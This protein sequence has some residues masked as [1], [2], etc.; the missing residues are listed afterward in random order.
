MTTV[1]HG[2]GY[3]AFAMWWEASRYVQTVD[4]ILVRLDVRKGVCERQ[5]SE[6]IEPSVW[7]ST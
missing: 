3:Q 7:T 4:C 1:D 2:Y 5:W 6:S